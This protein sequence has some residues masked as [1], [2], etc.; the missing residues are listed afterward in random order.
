MRHNNRC[1]PLFNGLKERK[2]VLGSQS[3][4]RVQL[5]QE[6]GLE[7]EIRP[8]DTDEIIPMGLPLDAVPAQLAKQKAEALLKTLAKDEILITADTIV[9]HKDRFLGKPNNKEEAKRY[10]RELS[11]SHHTVITGYAITT[12]DRQI[13][14]SVKS[15]IK[16]GILTENEINYYIEYY[17]VLDKAGAY[18]VQDWIGLIGV[19]EIKGSY[20]NVM[21][22]PTASLYHRLK[23][24][25]E[26]GK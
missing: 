24:F 4:R 19:T 3:P 16:F 12:S 2:I 10:L 7:F 26:E 5:L 17:E 20:H 25:L 8:S 9:I 1:H 14:E 11:D 23:K 13:I 18:G 15:E 21:G 22:L 6:L